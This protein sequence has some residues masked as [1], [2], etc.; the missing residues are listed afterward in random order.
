[1]VE[2]EPMDVSLLKDE[3]LDNEIEDIDKVRLVIWVP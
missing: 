2:E 1:V 3:G